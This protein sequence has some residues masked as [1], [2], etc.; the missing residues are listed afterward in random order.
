MPT[1]ESAIIYGALKGLWPIVIVIL[2]AIYSYNLMQATRAMDILREVL[3]SISD[4]KRI[5]VLLISGVSAV[6]WRLRRVTARR[7]RSPSAFWWRLD[8]RR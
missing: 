3:A 6:F 1:L 4:D 2:G 8:S 7:W 5:Q